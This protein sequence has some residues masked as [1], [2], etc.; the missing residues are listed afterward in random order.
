MKIMAPM[1]ALVL[2]EA[3]LGLV[4]ACFLAPQ[5]SNARDQTAHRPSA[6]T[7]LAAHI[8]SFAVYT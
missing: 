5:V 3:I 6:T 7:M 8:V 2:W 4:F 1:I